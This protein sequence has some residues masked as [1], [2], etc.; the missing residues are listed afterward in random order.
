MSKTNIIL[1]NEKNETA[2]EIS[3]K[4]PKNF[5]DLKN[6]IIENFQNLP[7]YFYIFYKKG[8]KK[9]NIINNE[10]YKKS[11]EILFI[12]PIILE[13]TLSFGNITTFCRKSK[14]MILES[15]I[16]DI[17]LDNN[18][19]KIIQ[20]EKEK[21]IEEKNNRIKQLEKEI[22]E[23]NKI[24]ANNIEKTID[25]LNSIYNAI[26]NINLKRVPKDNEKN[27]SHITKDFSSN[28]RNDVIDKISKLI[29]NDIDKIKQYI[30]NNNEINKE[31]NDYTIKISKTEFKKNEKNEEFNI[32]LEKNSKTEIKTK[33]PY[34]CILRIDKKY[35]DI[36]YDNLKKE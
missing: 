10:D 32:S 33:L 16:E 18:T 31:D 20:I 30:H 27:L 35:N 24:I 23:K 6:L 19:S 26:N 13:N 8:D 21:D 25:I 2:K 11:N 34:S 28:N 7:K 9:I 29:L 3:I 22:E 12:C 36:S 17:S 14:N 15:C 5:E 1:L 4:S